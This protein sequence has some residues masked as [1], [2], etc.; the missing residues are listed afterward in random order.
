MHAL[1]QAGTRQYRDPS[2]QISQCGLSWSTAGSA[3]GHISDS[4]QA[5]ALPW[6]GPRLVTL[7][8]LLCCLVFGLVVLFVGFLVGCFCVSLA[9]AV[10]Q[11]M[12]K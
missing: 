6:L 10:S 7:V 9:E 1:N 4:P 2:Q 11:P 8:Y 5:A 12:F 3:Q